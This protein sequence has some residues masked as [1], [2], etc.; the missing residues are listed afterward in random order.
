M[1][2]IGRQ[3]QRT[4][5][6]LNRRAFLQVGAS[7]VLGLSLADAL[8]AGHTPGSARAVILL[9]LWGG[10]S[11]LDT[12]DPKPHAPLEYRGPFGTIPTKLPGVRFCELF[13]QLA[14]VSDKLTLIR[15][16]HTQ[17]ND[18]G[19]A[20]TIGLT[21]SAAGGVDLGG[22]PLPGSPDRKSVV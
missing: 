6:T 2:L 15:S 22:K 8:Q 12:F 1:L 17:S 14:G 20:G 4:C 13:P 3:T 19:V 5:Q 7:S 21:G 18:H 9:W 16:L 10:P 11:H